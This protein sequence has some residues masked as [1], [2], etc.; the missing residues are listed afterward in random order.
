MNWASVGEFLAMGGYGVYVWGSV[1]TTV[2]LLWTECRM[3]RR[4]RRAALWGRVRNF[5]C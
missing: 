5:V 3:L 1:L 2:V 4:R